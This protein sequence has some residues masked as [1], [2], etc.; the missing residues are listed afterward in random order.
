MYQSMMYYKMGPGYGGYGM[1]YG[2]YGYNPYGMGYGG[3]RR[4]M[5]LNEFDCLGGCP[6]Q[7]FCDYGVCRCRN[8]YDAR[9]VFATFLVA[10]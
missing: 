2:G 3:G 6:M 10:K 7:A 4:G 1:G 9:Y 8:G 5:L